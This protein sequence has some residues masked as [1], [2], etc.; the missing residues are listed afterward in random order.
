MFRTQALLIIILLLARIGQAQHNF[1]QYSVQN[2]L[3]QS[4][5]SDI[6]EDQFGYL[7]F[8]TRGGGLSKFDGTKF[9]NITI[10]D[11][12]KSNIV[13]KVIEDSK[14]NIWAGTD[15]G[16]TKYDGKVF[17]TM[18]LN[19]EGSF[20]VIRNIFEDTYGN[21]WASSARGGVSLIK[22]STIATYNSSNGF[23]DSVVSDIASDKLGKVYISTIMDGL[24]VYE[25]ANFK[26]VHH[27]LLRENYI[28]ELFLDRS[29]RF[30]LA[31]HKGVIIKDGSN[32]RLL[33]QHPSLEQPIYTIGQGKDEHLW[34]ATA[35]GIIEYHEAVLQ[36]YTHADGF[37]NVGVTSIHGDRE[38]NMWF[39]TF[40]EGVYK[41]QGEIF[42][43][44]GKQDN[45][46]Q[47][48]ILAITQD[49]Q[50]RMYFGT[51]G[52]GMLVIDGK[53]VTSL[54]MNDGLS[55]NSIISAVTD[56]SGAVWAG[57]PGSGLNRIYNQIIDTYSTEEGLPD[58]YIFAAMRDFS[59]SLWFASRKGLLR[60]N[61]KKFEIANSSVRLSGALLQLKDST[62]LIG[63][64]HGVMQYNGK[65]F[66]PFLKDKLFSQQEILSLAQD[67]KGTVWIGSNGKGLCKYN[68]ESNS[69]GYISENDGLASNLIY[70][71]IFDDG[72]KLFVGTEKGIDKITFDSLGK[73]NAIRNFNQTEGFKGVE[74]NQNAAY[75]TKDGS[76]L[77]GSVMGVYRYNREID[78]PNTHRPITHLTNVKLFFESIDWSQ[79]SDSTSQWFNIPQNLVLPHDKNHLIFEFLGSSLKNPDKVRYRYKIANLDAAWSPI[80]SSTQAIYNNI[81]PGKY[82]FMVKS[83]NDEGVWDENPVTLLF[84]IK[85]ALWQTWYFYLALG[86][87]ALIIIRIW[88]NYR[89]GR[90]L[91]QVMQIENIKKEERDKIRKRMARDFHDELGNKLATISVSTNILSYAL[92]DKSKEVESLLHTIE[93]SSKYLFSG[94]KD[95][96]WSIDMHS[97]NVSE[98]FSYLKDFGEDYFGKVNIDFYAEQNIGEKQTKS[99]PAGC[100]RQV[101]MIFKE[102]MTNILKHAEADSVHFSLHIKMNTFNFILKDNGK[103]M[104]NNNITGHGLQN[105]Q[106]RAAEIK[107]HLV[108]DSDHEGTRITLE[109]TT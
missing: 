74:A 37:S 12:L 91:K 75:K 108:I 66:T 5:V 73:I 9:H 93:S 40:G 79:Y 14:G 101:V 104:C 33:S 58:S 68:A 43:P 72:G 60:Y 51:L 19:L 76:I 47:D 98:I 44:V 15:E 65:V 88:N 25:G 87:F 36:E 62:L 99:L 97:D 29:G 10:R 2:G 50:Q 103:G 34:L 28:Y 90:K 71:L 1:V 64:S 27:P 106:N 95:F 63:T 8:A 92:K 16:L 57:T 13:Y 53:K 52:G 11:G 109:G 31:T 107:G 42:S 38:G 56:K 85:P 30:Y 41:Y 32:F 48:V 39:S 4:Q 86:I 82:T 7:W 77:F 94:T 24:Y 78:V 49:P 59:G 102:G 54:T 26:K 3:A 61:G 100:S 81:P 55:S 84:E 80:V 17:A 105:M 45:E 22:D 89:I 20:N 83:S 21:I 46:S 96:I 23:T 69:I 35:L 67:E 18:D 70:N 6:C